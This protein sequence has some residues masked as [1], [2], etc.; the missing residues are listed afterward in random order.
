MEGKSSI[1]KTKYW[2]ASVFFGG[3]NW[4]SSK[5]IEGLVFFRA[6]IEDYPPN[7]LRILN[8]FEIFCGWGLHLVAP[9]CAI[10]RDYLSDT[11]LLRAMGFLVSQHGQLGAIPP[12]PFLSLSPSESMRSGGAIP[13]LKKGISAI[14]ARYLW[15][16]GKWVRHPPLRY[17]LER[18]LRDMGGYLALGR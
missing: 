5:H 1:F 6:D 4:G 7:F 14:L 11:P 16:Q 12:P 9:Y 2:R 13:P 10:L 18:V 17:Y 8:F 15:K 3:K